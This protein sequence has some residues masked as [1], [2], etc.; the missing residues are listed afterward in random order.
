M[1]K[2]YPFL[3]FALLLSY[4]SFGQI[5]ANNRTYCRD[6]NSGSN[7]FNLIQDVTLN[8]ISPNASQVNF[9]QISVTDP[10]IY[11]EGATGIGYF[12]LGVGSYSIT[13]QVCE[14]ANPTNCATATF[15]VNNYAQPF[16][17]VIQPNCNSF[18][19]E[20]IFY[21]LPESGWSITN[22]SSSGE[23]FQGNSY[24]W[25]FPILTAGTFVFAVTDTTT[26]CTFAPIFVTILPV[27][28][29]A[30]PTVVPQTCASPI[31][32]ITLNDLPATGTWTLSYKTYNGT[33]TIITGT[34]TTYT[35]TGITP[36]YYY[37]KVTNELGCTSQEVGASV[38]NLNN[39]LSGT[40]TAA[41]VDYNN[42]GVTN[43]G[44]IIQYDIAITNNLTCSMETVNYSIENS[45]NTIGTFANLAA[46]ATANGTLNY[47]LTQYDI[48]NGS[49]FNWIAVNGISN[50]YETYIKL[51]DQ[52]QNVTLSLSD[53]IKL[54]A[55]FDTNN[56]GI[57]NNGEQNSSLGNFT[58]QL[59][60]DGSDH[61]LYSENG[62]NIIYESNPTNTYNLSYNLYNTCTDQ[63]DVSATNY[64][65][66]TVPTGSGITIYNF[67]ISQSPCRDIRIDLSGW[68][69]RPGFN[70]TNYITFRNTGNQTLTSGTI[71]FTKDNALTITSISEATAL[72]TATGFTY[73]FTNL[74]PNEA[75]SLNVTLLVPTIPIVALGQLLTN[76][77]SITIP[78]N[79]INPSNNSSALTQ[80]IIGSFDPNDKTE[81][82][83]GKILHSGFTADDYLT[84]MIRF[85]NTGTA[86]AINIRVNDVLDEQLDETSIK[87]VR[88]SHPYV[89]D[90]VGNNLTWRFDGVNLP[91]SIPGDEVT[92]HGHIV[93]QIKPS[94]GFA[95]GDIIPNTADI[96]FDFNPAI[97]TNTC[98]TEFVPFL[99]VNAFASDAFEYYPNPTSDIVTFN[100]KNTSTT[101][102][103]IEV[104]DVL[105][106]TLLIKTNN[107]STASIDLSSL[108]KGMYLVK[109]KAAGQEKLVKILKE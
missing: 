107:Y 88:A 3:F 49:V 39:G 86:S 56:D 21:G 26:G 30:P 37:F 94:P 44:D 103:T 109:V 11:L 89:L 36:D 61:Y 2:N 48:N 53:G 41:Y 82:H 105:G 24:Q 78:V 42:D 38:G 69:P 16:V 102:E 75:R 8:G 65:N 85:E 93:F 60:N 63:Y 97:V 17:S 7:L 46:G 13:Y 99:G 20:V 90:R 83:G 57:Q 80:P 74:L 9:T 35:I 52:N 1:K 58:Y 28:L 10:G 50:G 71:T 22:T 66:I 104:M 25:N 54:N 5:V 70:Y 101:I 100:L 27:L 87:M 47:P 45:N 4:S 108:S 18:F 98:T 40:L 6:V 29:T 84:Y 55:F 72:T 62:T 59:N 96:F 77:A 67:P 12:P 19:G 51:F 33:P 91:P 81:S 14:I 92:G 76:S 68:A 23:V 15:T 95:I 34:G 64:S 79:D 73:N 32:T 106:K 31:D 43:L